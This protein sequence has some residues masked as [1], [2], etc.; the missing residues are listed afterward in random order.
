[1]KKFIVITTINEKT[2]ALAAY[3]QKQGWHTI[4]VGD[5]KSK[6]L[7]S[8]DHLTFLPVDDQ[9]KLGFGLVNRLPFNHY[10]RKNIGYLYAMRAGADIIYDTDDDNIPYPDWE[11]EAFKCSNL[12]R[13]PDDF[14]NI[15][16]HFSSDYIWPRGFPLDLISRRQT[17]VAEKSSPVNIGVWQGLTDKEPDVDA[18]YRL[19]INKPVTFERKPSVALP[20]GK[21]CPFNSQN[22]LW[23]KEAFPFLYLPSTVGFRT[24]DIY[25]GYIAQR[26]LWTRGLHLG[27]HQACGFQERNPHD[28]M[29]DFTDEIECVLNVR[30]MANILGQSDF[31]GDLF[32]NLLSAYRLLHQQRLI[33]DN[34]LSGVDAWVNDCKCYT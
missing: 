23:S 32:D 25:R 9:Q 16:S 4:V 31:L 10:A 1:M 27:F 15:Y 19:V 26:L 13:C 21:F 5:K 6:P 12:I 29:D 24:T 28:L 18:V 7:E 20:V 22:T 34:E 11:P 14:I 8:G 30:R 3:E 2:R 17:I 33:R